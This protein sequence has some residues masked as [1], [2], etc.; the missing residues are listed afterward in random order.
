MWRGSQKNATIGDCAA[1]ARIHLPIV[2]ADML[3]CGALGVSRATLHGFAE[4]IVER[5]LASRLERWVERRAAGEPV[6][7]ILGRRGFW[8]FDLEVSPDALI[9]RPDTE[10]LVAAVLPLIDDGCRVLD[11]GTGSGA[12]ALAIASEKPTASVT[13]TDLDPHCIAL[14]RRNAT[15]LGIELRTLV[16]DRFKGLDERFELIVSNP[17]YVAADDPHLL[18]GDLRFEPRLAL[19]GGTDGLGFLKRLIAEAPEHLLPGGWLAVEH[20]CTQGTAVGRL[21]RE[22]GFV[23]ESTC[24]DIEDRPR[25]TIGRLAKATPRREA[26]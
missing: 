13:A 18:H 3:T 24:A 15:R 1:F 10:T 20:G 6:A 14:C 26:G 7:Y 22:H 21:F 9:P 25:A 23:G 4:R 5:A 12:V 19:V 2:E 16:A 8:T 11:V 17:P